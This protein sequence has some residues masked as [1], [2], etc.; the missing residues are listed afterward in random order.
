MS[1]NRK[2]DLVVRWTSKL[3]ETNSLPKVLEKSE[4]ISIF[5]GFHMD[6]YYKQNHHQNLMGSK[7]K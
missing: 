6:P 2:E 4:D 5:M 7:K 3:G 1:S